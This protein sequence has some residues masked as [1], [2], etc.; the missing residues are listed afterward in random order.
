MAS[1]LDMNFEAW[2]AAGNSAAFQLLGRTIRRAHMA[3]PFAGIIK[4]RTA[5]TSAG[6]SS[7]QF[8]YKKRLNSR[9]A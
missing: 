7:R 2:G 4:T 5:R 8:C 6:G 9:F 3:P 1:S